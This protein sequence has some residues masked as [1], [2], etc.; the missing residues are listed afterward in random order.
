[1]TS[2]LSPMSLA[3]PANH[4]AAADGT[5]DW[6]DRAA[7]RDED[8]YLF[9]APEDES[10]SQKRYRIAHALKACAGC[11]VKDACLRDAIEK[12]DAWGIRGGLLPDQVKAILP[13]W[14]RPT[15]P[16]KAPAEAVPA[17]VAAMP[18]PTQDCPAPSSI[19]TKLH[20]SLGERSCGA[21]REYNRARRTGS[22]S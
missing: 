14:Q 7:C 15:P 11:P 18:T 16:A 5:G 17:R 19:T 9:H 3:R 4:P 22:K 12:R 1:M 20:G 10:P 2:R 21:C 13:P 6:R 8:P